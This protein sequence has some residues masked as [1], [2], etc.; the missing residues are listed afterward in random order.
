M[1]VH[2]VAKNR[3][4][5]C[6]QYASKEKNIE[7]P[8]NFMTFLRTLV[9][10]FTVQVRIKCICCCQCRYLAFIKGFSQRY[11][12][13]TLLK[14]EPRKEIKLSGWNGYLCFETSNSRTWSS[15]FHFLMG[16]LVVEILNQRQLINM[17]KLVTKGHFWRGSPNL[18]RI[19]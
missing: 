15:G 7:V 10:A 3:E 19:F 18:K 11:K 8:K 5:L 16:F 17:H 4:V 12:I 14:M 1:N 9:I 2:K 13:C 6:K